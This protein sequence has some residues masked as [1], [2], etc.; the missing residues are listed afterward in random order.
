MH[1]LADLDQ[2]VTWLH[3][4]GSI[5]QSGFE[6]ARSEVANRIES[7]TSRPVSVAQ[8]SQEI[9]SAR[10]NTDDLSER[11]LADLSLR[12][13][14]VRA[15]SERS[16]QNLSQGIEHLRSSAEQNQR[17]LVA[18]LVQ[19]AERVERQTTAAAAP[20]LTQ[21]VAQPTTAV[22]A[23]PV[24]KPVP[25]PAPN[26][27]SNVAPKQTTS[28][29]KPDLDVRGIANWTVL[30]VFDGTA[31][32]KGPRGVV[33]VAVG[34]TIPGVGRVQGIMRSGRRWVVATTKGVITPQ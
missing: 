4:T 15:A 2:A 28:E 12:V 13:D 22:P 11:A 3:Q 19:L 33:E 5:V 26:A 25:Q 31:V 7:F 9:I 29:M 30:D 21:P 14:Q 20:A 27:K 6:A 1:R 16:A 34:D 8:A 24:A 23:K 10:S 32:L 18:K 17:E